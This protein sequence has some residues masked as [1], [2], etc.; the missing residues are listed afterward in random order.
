V[1]SSGV[2][3]RFVSRGKRSSSFPSTMR[4]FCRFRS[5]RGPVCSWCVYATRLKFEGE[6]STS[7]TEARSRCR[8]D[9]PPSGRRA[10][11]AARFRLRRRPHDASGLFRA[12]G[13]RKRD[14]AGR[15][16]AAGRARAVTDL[17]AAERRSEREVRAKAK[18][19][20]VRERKQASR[21][22]AVVREIT[23]RP[24][25][26]R[27]DD[28][29]W[30]DERDASQ[31]FTRADLHSRNDDIAARPKPLSWA[32]TGCLRRSMVRRGSTVRVRQMA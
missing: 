23:S 13:G 15:E 11:A 10:L 9:S 8:A 27:S 31:P 3:A 25:R 16:A 22:K 1:H 28:A 12:T 14:Q 18:E 2:R 5:V 30:L 26:S 32:A 29:A 7:T 19:Q 21:A 4:G 6:T 24:G 17:R 20:A